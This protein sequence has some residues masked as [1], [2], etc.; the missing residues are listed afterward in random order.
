MFKGSAEFAARHGGPPSPGFRHSPT[1][2]EERGPC[3]PLGTP[4]GLAHLGRCRVPAP[5]SGP[6]CQGS[7]LISAPPGKGWRSL[8]LARREAGV[9]RTWGGVSRTATALRSFLHF[10]LPAALI[11]APGSA[12]APSP[13]PRAQAGRRAGCAASPAPLSAGVGR[14]RCPDPLGEQQGSIKGRGAREAGASGEAGEGDKEGRDP[15]RHQGAGT[16]QRSQEGGEA[17]R[18]S[19]SRAAGLA[20]PSR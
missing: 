2:G 1:P 11:S 19:G 7:L 18:A 13:R 8:P 14:C 6:P 5:A 15:S 12:R 3:S 10:P 20:L 17:R 16:G 4:A 9:Q